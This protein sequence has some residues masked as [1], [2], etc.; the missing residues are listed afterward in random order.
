MKI[1]NF[2]YGGNSVY[3]EELRPLIESLGHSLICIHEWDSANVKYNRETVYAELQKADIIVL[4]CNYKEQSCKSN[5]RLTQAMALGKPCIVSP[6]PAYLKIIKKYPSCAL[7]ASNLEEWKMNIEFLKVDAN[8]EDM[9]KKAIQAASEFHI[10]VI[11]SKWLEILNEKTDIIIP[12]FNNLPCLKLCLDSIRKCTSCYNLIVVNNGNDEALHQFLSEQ[13]DITYIKKDRMTFS[14]A[15]NTG[16]RQSIAKYVCILNDDVIVSQNW[17][18]IMINSCTKGIGAVGPL[19][20]CDKSWL[21]NHDIVIDGLSLVPGVH[22]IGDVKPDSIHSFKSTINEIHQRDWIAFYCTLMPRE[23]VQKTGLLDEQF[24]NSGED[25]D[26]CQR[27]TRFG[28][29]IIQ[30]YNSFVFHFGAVSRKLL[31]AD[32]KDA[33]QKDQVNTTSYMREKLDKQHVVIYTGQS[34]EKWDWKKLETGIGGSENWVVYLAREFVKLGYRVTA[35]ID[36]ETESVDQGVKYLKYTEYPNYIEQNFIDFFISSRV[37][38]PFSHKIRYGRNFVMIH[39][40]WLL[41][42]KEAKL[43]LPMVYKYICL[44]DWHRDFVSDYH[45][46]S[47]EKI[48]I[49]PHGVDFNRY[50]KKLERHPHRLIYSSSPDRGLDTLLYCFD[51]LKK[52]IPDLELHVF[53]GFYNWSEA[54]KV[55][56]N[57]QELAWCNSIIEAMKKPGVFDHGR[58]G[59]QE[60]A[61]WQMQSSLWAYPTDFE[62]TFCITAIECQAAGLPIIASNY[63]GLKTTVKNSAMLLGNGTKGQSLTKEYREEFIKHCHDILTNKNTWEYWSQKSLNNVKKYTWANTAKEWQKLFYET[64]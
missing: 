40:I 55:R 34:W 58:V 51:F 61:D 3:A 47:K 56:N 19:S 14:Q 28:Y 17:L 54:I 21:H 13:K 33:Y 53:Y 57:P 11:G 12:T 15:V 38:D 6:L 22:K 2:G 7:V 5:N 32:N 27:I 35:F 62:E 44:S 9:S 50:N 23:V 4:P 41:G 52:D 37:T 46:L 64:I 39:D 8:R 25:V 31:E 30:N 26:Y 42:G 20:N 60:L 1:Y 29:K 49:V 10:D 59:Q 16:L 36:C 43:Y 48:S 45:G 63:A 18:S 24:T